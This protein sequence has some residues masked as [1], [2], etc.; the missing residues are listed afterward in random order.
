MPNIKKFL[1]AHRTRATPLRQAAAASP[2]LELSRR[3][4]TP[5]AI[6][7]PGFTRRARYGAAANQDHAAG[8]GTETPPPVDLA[9][10]PR[11]NRR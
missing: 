7:Q 9:A 6:P 1:A 10:C 11:S 4:R 5:T 3:R 2:P 8:R